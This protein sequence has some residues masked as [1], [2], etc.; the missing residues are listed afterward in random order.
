MTHG[1]IWT[2][3]FGQPVGSLPSKIRPAVVMQNDLLGI[4]DLNTVVVIPFTSN[5][6]RADFEP[7]ILIEKEET[8][9][10]KDSVAVIHLIGAVNKFCLEQKVSKLSEENYRRRK[11]EGFLPYSL[12]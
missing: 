4:K 1:E 11:N 7:N 10:S 5:L 12:C 6:D 2:I 8:G 3:D 9:L